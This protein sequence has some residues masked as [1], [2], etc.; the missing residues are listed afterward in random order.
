MTRNT[1]VMGIYTDRAT[2]SDATNVL[3]KAGFR[4]TDI[5]VLSSDNQGTKDFSLEEHTKALDGAATGAVVGAV[6]GAALAWFISI[7]PEQYV[8]FYVWCLRSVTYAV[9]SQRPSAVPPVLRAS[10]P[11]RRCP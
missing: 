5:A 6:V 3:H 8:T 7:Q 9:P 10:A 4:A 2:A 11:V 1:S